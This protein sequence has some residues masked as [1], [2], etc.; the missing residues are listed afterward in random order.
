MPQKCRSIIYILF[1]QI[2][3]QHSDRGL[4]TNSVK[5]VQHMTL[6]LSEGDNN[7]A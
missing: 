5:F 3:Q 6:A 4:T 7:V 2:M 1:A